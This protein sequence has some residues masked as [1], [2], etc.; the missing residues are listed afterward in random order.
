MPCCDEG[1]AESVLSNGPG[2]LERLLAAGVAEL[3]LAM[4]QGQRDTLVRY[5]TLLSKWNRVYSL[6]AVRSPEQMVIRHLLD[7]LSV[8]PWVHRG[9]VLDV[10]SGA[11]LP[12]L[13]LAVARPELFFVLLDGNRKK[14]RFCRQAVA[15]LGIGNVTVACVRLEHYCPQE[16]YATIISRAFGP[17]HSSLAHYRRLST[18]DGRVL[19]MMG[20]QPP[21]D[22]ASVAPLLECAKVVPLSVPGLDADRHLM[23][24]DMACIGLNMGYLGERS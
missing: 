2:R 7:S 4:D 1:R 15:E 14:S 17:V 11:G 6:T 19:A 9:P 3:P 12:G 22:D 13:V 8:T 23:V 10:G 20:K 18:T 5:V 21:A 24:L 16:R